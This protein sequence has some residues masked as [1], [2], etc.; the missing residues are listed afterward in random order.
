MVLNSKFID[1][2]SS[3]FK[4]LQTD[5]SETTSSGIQQTQEASHVN[6]LID[7]VN[8]LQLK[9][10]VRY[11]DWSIDHPVREFLWRRLAGLHAGR[12]YSEKSCPELLDKSPP[13][14]P[15]KLPAFIDV[16]YCRFFYLN[17]EGQKSVEKVIWS[18]AREHPEVAFC[19]LVYPLTALF[20]H[21]MTD[22]EALS[23]ISLLIQSNTP[24]NMTASNSSDFKH[25]QTEPNSNKKYAMTR[26]LLPKSKTQ[27]SKDAYVLIKLSNSFSVSFWPQR[28]L[29][30]KQREDLAKKNDIDPALQEWLKWIF[31]GL[32]FPHL[33]R[34]IDCFLVEGFKF[35]LR[36]GL[37][38]LLLLKR[39]ANDQDSLTLDQMISFCE[40]IS[41]TPNQLIH[42]A[43]SLSRVTSTKIV[44]QYKKA[45]DVVRRNP[46]M[47]GL[48]PMPTPA[49]LRRGDM[50]KNVDVQI[51]SRIAPG[52][53][54]SNI[55]DWYH[56]DQLWEWIP[57]RISIKE[58]SIAFTTHD[59]GCSLRTFFAKTESL[60]PTIL[61]IK[62]SEGEVFGAFCSE[63]WSNRLGRDAGH[64]FG[65][66]ETF[67]FSLK[68]RVQK[69]SWVGLNSS[70]PTSPTKSRKVQRAIVSS[71]LFMTATANHIIIGSGNGSGIWLDEDLNRGKSEKCDTFNNHP[72]ASA[73]DFTC[74]ALEVIAFN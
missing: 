53:I 69:Y 29:I 33:V 17:E 64:F 63:S 20:L 8:L 23:S 45:D 65:N 47:T 31:I 1:D 6:G 37:T 46:E 26:S 18:L 60:E 72:L 48:T 58:P 55:I 19:P 2:P 62:T 36:I 15:K 70:N 9:K 68:P 40:S 51:T 39:S 30:R 16:T 38:L 50:M 13:S 54:N 25:H 4:S 7:S 57:E 5:W 12:K 73:G 11:K 14:T 10:S 52:T 43:C 22:K 32:P 56:L 34:I 74:T 59:D 42:L 71:Q 61:L 67:L 3:L 28:G 35:L 24:I 49:A 21:F 44:K 66:G 41:L 27:I